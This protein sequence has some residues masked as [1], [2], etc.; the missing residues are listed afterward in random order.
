MQL[1]LNVPSPVPSNRIC[2]NCCNSPAISRSTVLPAKSVKFLRLLEQIDRHLPRL[3]FFC[4]PVLAKLYC[5]L[6]HVIDCWPLCANN[7]EPPL[8]AEKKLAQNCSIYRL[9]EIQFQWRRATEEEKC[10][11]HKQITAKNSNMLCRAAMPFLA[12]L[13]TIY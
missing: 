12:T 2:Q 3:L 4:T 11:K 7:A 8:L 13:S 1:P 5:L 6:T 10:A 9:K